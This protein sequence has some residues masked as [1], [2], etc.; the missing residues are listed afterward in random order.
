MTD[1]HPF[2]SVTGIGGARGAIGLLAPRWRQVAD[3]HFVACHFAGE[4]DLQGFH[5]A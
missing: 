4:L 5:E 3:E 1:N 2:Y